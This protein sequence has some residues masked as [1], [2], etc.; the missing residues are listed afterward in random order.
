MRFGDGLIGL[1]L[2]LL[3]VSVMLYVRGFP[4]LAGH[5]YGPDL[6]P[7]IV[8][9][10]MIV[11]GGLLILRAVR[12]GLPG[13]FSFGIVAPFNTGRAALSVF[14]IVLSILSFVFLGE[15]VGFPIITF[16]TLLVFF[17]WLRGGLVFPICMALALTVSFD[18][19]FRVLLRVPVPMGLL[20]G[21]I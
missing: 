14:L 10:G 20:E 21:V 19:L 4:H 16:V 18:L 8:A 9:V 13:G 17:L 11:C 1:L 12:A 3:G 2:A 5:Y 15:R 6:F 7:N